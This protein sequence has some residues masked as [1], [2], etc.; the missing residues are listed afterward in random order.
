[1]GQKDVKRCFDDSQW[2]W[3]LTFKHCLLFISVSISVRPVAITTA[4]VT[5]T[6]LVTINYRSAS[7]TGISVYHFP[8]GT[9]KDMV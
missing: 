4:T 3:H 8:T 7:R 6:Q 5:A 1:M 9:G 2:E